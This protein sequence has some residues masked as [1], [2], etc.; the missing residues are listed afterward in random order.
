MP[1]PFEVDAHLRGQ[2]NWQRG[3][4][5]FQKYVSEQLLDQALL[6]W[7]ERWESWLADALTRAGAPPK[8]CQL[9]RGRPTAWMPVLAKR[10]PFK[11][12]V[13]NS[14]RVRQLFNVMHRVA[15]CIRLVRGSS[16]A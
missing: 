11:S 3:A 5:E 15:H 12:H 2:D 8:A 13:Q 10:S 16:L 7:S 4:R 14:L 9:G 6:A 1:K